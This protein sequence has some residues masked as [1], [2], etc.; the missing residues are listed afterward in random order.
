MDQKTR[1]SLELNKRSI[2]ELRSRLVLVLSVA[3]FRLVDAECINLLICIIT[4]MKN[5]EF[6]CLSIQDSMLLDYVNKF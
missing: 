4:V 2:S 5:T 3:L 1:V 6:M